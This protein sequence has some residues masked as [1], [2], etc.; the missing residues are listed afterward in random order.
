MSDD[1][2]ESNR[3]LNRRSYL[4]HVAAA[5][6]AVGIGSV[7]GLGTGS[8]GAQPTNEQGE[9]VVAQF[10]GTFTPG[11][12]ANQCLSCVEP[13]CLSEEV[14]TLFPLFTGL[15]G[16]CFT[17]EEIPGGADFVTLKAGL[18][19]YVAPVGNNTTFCLP[20]GS[21][22][23]SNATFYRCGGEPTPALMWFKVTCDE[24]TV[25]TENI[26]DGTTLTATVTFLDQDGT[27]SEETFQATVQNDTTTF[28]L[29]GNLNPTNLVIS[30]G[31]LVLDDQQVV[32]E[33]A[34]CTKKPPDP[35]TPDDPRIETLRVTCD[36]ITIT[37][38]D[39][40][41]GDTLFVTVTFVGDIVETYDIPV[42]EDGTATVPLPGDLDPSRLVIVYDGETLYDD[43]VQALDAPCA[44]VPPK[45]PKKKKKGKKYTRKKRK[46]ERAK[47]EYERYK[48][49]YEKGDGDQK[50]L[51]KK[52]G[53]YEKAKREYEREKRCRTY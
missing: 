38:A 48:K 2:D 5:G 19:C 21:P 44:E 42:D 34:P 43:H 36:A 26:P 7:A 52:R 25:T 47:R 51:Q 28:V 32:A 14:N 15:T 18:N 22:D 29:P 4:T 20:P 37:T 31:D 45:P 50:T 35:P 30:L 9:S 33:D 49:K 8:V 6:G 12:Q 10:C 16:Q 3:E 39:I 11:P 13:L 40:P 23:I 53:A 27:V 1:H 24:I 46:Y 17:P 41:A